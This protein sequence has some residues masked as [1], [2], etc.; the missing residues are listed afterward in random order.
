MC[1][2]VAQASSAADDAHAG[3]LRLRPDLAAGS[4]AAAGLRAGGRLHMLHLSMDVP[5]PLSA[6]LSQVCCHCVCRALLYSSL[7]TGCFPSVRELAVLA[8]SPLSWRDGLHKWAM[9]RCRMCCSPTA[10]C[11]G[12]SWTCA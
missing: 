10:R 5:W 9:L 6:I 1:A 2:D 11:L 12:P 3:R 4:C 8:S 7:Y